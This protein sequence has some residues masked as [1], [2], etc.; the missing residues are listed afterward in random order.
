MFFENDPVLFIVGNPDAG[1]PTTPKVTVSN[2]DITQVV[3]SFP[4]TTAVSKVIARSPDGFA[5][6]YTDKIDGAIV[7][8]DNKAGQLTVRNISNR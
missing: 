1:T 6:I 5:N 7:L 2:A 3:P 8:W 4:N